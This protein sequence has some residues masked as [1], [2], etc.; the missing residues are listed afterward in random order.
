M[1]WYNEPQDWQ[2]RA[3]SLSLFVTAKTD[4]WRETHYAF[5]VDD[6]PFYFQNRGGE[7]SVEVS[8]QADYQT[9]Y[10]QMGLMLRIDAANWIKFGVEYVDEKINIS[11]V[12]TRD[13]SD[14]SI[15]PLAHQPEQIWLKAIRRLDAV[16]L[17]YALDGTNYQMVRLAH[18]PD[19]R[20]LMVGMM[21]ASPDGEGF[22]AEF[23]D[24][25]I[26]HLPD[27]RRTQWLANNP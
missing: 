25:S 17:H 14:W 19:N 23:K 5:T 20:P 1:Q 22:Q 7:F 10:D 8:I 27:Q 9:R 15:L 24:F 11:A 21:A 6:G 12:V 18:F 16:E 2:F 26:T 3:N 13:K 4:Y